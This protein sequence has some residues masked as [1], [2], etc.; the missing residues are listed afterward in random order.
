MINTTHYYQE[1]GYIPSGALQKMAIFTSIAAPLLGFV[2]G[3]ITHW[4]D[5]FITF[6]GGPM[7][8]AV[9]MAGGSLV[10][11]FSRKVK[12]RN[13]TALFWTSLYGGSL[14]WYSSW[15]VWLYAETGQFIANPLEFLENLELL[16]KEGTFILPSGRSLI[17]PFTPKGNILYF[18][19]L[20]EAAS[21]ILGTALSALIKENKSP[22]CER[23]DQ[24]ATEKT[25]LHTIESIHLDNEHALR[26]SLENIEQEELQGIQSTKTDDSPASLK[27]TLQWCPSCV[28]CFYLSVRYYHFVIT[29][30]GKYRSSSSIVYFLKV[31]EAQT[32]SLKRQLN[33]WRLRCNELQTISDTHE[34]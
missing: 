18:A 4:F 17:V 19:W 32:E 15:I 25:D 20:V 3:Y 6:F 5:I 33:G 26:A 27:F 30:R 24:W 28:D 21:I 14:I 29:A 34:Y 10:A 12:N 22:F 31:S 23:C 9:A 2:H 11:S 8:M 13:G 7:L 1:S 16:A